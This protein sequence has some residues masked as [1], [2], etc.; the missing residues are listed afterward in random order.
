MAV[1]ERCGDRRPLA[2]CLSSQGSCLSLSG[3]WGAAQPNFERALRVAREDGQRAETAAIYT[4][5]G[6]CAKKV[7]CFDEAL[8]IDR[9]LGHRDAV[10]RRLNNIG[11]VHMEQGDWAAA[12]RVMTQGLQHCAQFQIVFSAP[13]F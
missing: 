8:V 13:L 11:N 5:R 4:N 3:R 9:E 1:A 6:I 7:G 12:L 2:G 10:A